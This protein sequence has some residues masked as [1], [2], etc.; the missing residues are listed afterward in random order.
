MLLFVGNVIYLKSFS[1]D[2]QIVYITRALNTECIQNREIAYLF[3]SFNFLIVHSAESILWYV[4]H[5]FVAHLNVF[6]YPLEN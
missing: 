5:A 3:F 1:T 2:V 6:F 4:W